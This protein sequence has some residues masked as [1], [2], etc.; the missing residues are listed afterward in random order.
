MVNSIYN[1]AMMKALYDEG[2]DYL[3]SFWPFAV[4]AIPSKT[5]VD[6]NYIQGKLKERYNLIVPLHVIEVILSRAERKNT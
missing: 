1:Y 2:Q 3:D 4:M 6:I 5:S